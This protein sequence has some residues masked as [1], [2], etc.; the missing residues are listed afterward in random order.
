LEQASTGSAPLGVRIRDTFL[1]PAR[2]VAGIVP[3]KPWLD[4]L[5]IST[6][7]AVLSVLAMPDEVFLESMREAVT[8][9]G[10]PVE[11]T[12]PPEEI[13]RWGRSIGMLAMLGTHPVVA[14][15]LA[16]ALTFV[17][18]V[19]GGGA[20]TFR[21]Y[22]SLTTHALMI[23]AL[24]TIV[25]VTLQLT[26]ASDGDLTLGAFFDPGD[27]PGLLLASLAA[28]DPFLLWMT[29]VLGLCAHA[30]DP[31]HPRIRSVLLLVGGYFLLVLA[32][33]W[34]LAP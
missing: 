13:V 28:I 1:A 34:V 27:R 26:T 3:D 19:A 33:T 16:A 24:G 9:R 18:S 10:R 12:S 4:V 25:S 5:L 22:L 23:P 15:T 6:A 31:R 8:R 20:G 29:V 32:S 2:L 14:V 7:I 11:I 30:L 21:D 17:F